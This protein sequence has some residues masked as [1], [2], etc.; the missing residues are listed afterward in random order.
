MYLYSTLVKTLSCPKRERYIANANTLSGLESRLDETLEEIRRY[1]NNVAQARGVQEELP[2]KRRLDGQVLQTLPDSVRVWMLEKRTWHQIFGPGAKRGAY[3]P[4]VDKILL[5]K[6]S[7]CRKT[8]IHESLHSV[9]IFNDPRNRDKY[10]MTRLF[11]EG[12]TEF[13][14]GLLLFRKHKNCHENWRLRRFPQWC[15]A[16]YPR[17]TK[18]FLAFC[19]CANVQ[20]LLDLY[21][22]THTND[23]LVGWSEFIRAI[24]RDTG[25]RFKDV[26][27]EGERI[28]LMMAFK[29]ECERQFGKKF[30]KLQK[31]LD[32]SKVF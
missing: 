27:K 13:L 24:R 22:G 12:A 10:E 23:L 25:K 9:S 30:R 5:E 16:S 28:G 20:S 19:G 32:Y 3:N 15:S 4:R 29:N 1:L 2:L 17:Q 11:A 18:T 6:D 14:T 7:W 21:F 8:M 26:F 31:L